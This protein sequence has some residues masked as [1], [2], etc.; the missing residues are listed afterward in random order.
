M[1]LAT[2]SSWT[3]NM[4]PLHSGEGG[5]AAWL[6]RYAIAR[7]HSGD[8]SRSACSLLD[9]WNSGFVSGMEAAARS[10]QNAAIVSR[11]RPEALGDVPMVDSFNQVE[12]LSDALL[13]AVVKRCVELQEHYLDRTCPPSGSRRSSISSLSSLSSDPEDDDSSPPLPLPSSSSVNARE[14]SNT[15]SVAPHRKLNHQG[16]RL[17]QLHLS[18]MSRKTRMEGRR[19]AASFEKAITV[20]C[21]IDDLKTS[22]KPKFG[23]RIYRHEELELLG[24]RTERWDG[25][26]VTSIDSDPGDSY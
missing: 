10:L 26:L 22:V 9:S 14:S 24:I 2:L 13:D 6:N 1:K 7:L 21:E 23:R 16:R 11:V 12:T 3:V 4:L 25:R 8:P 20:S 5:L 18:G 17:Q 15:T 19:S